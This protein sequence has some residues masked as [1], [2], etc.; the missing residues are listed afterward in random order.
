MKPEFIIDISGSGESPL[1]ALHS[2]AVIDPTLGRHTSQNFRPALGIYNTSISRICS[3]LNK[4]CSKL[5]EY[6]NTSSDRSVLLKKE[7][8]RSEIIDYL[9][10]SLYAAA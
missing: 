1:E 10:L 8:L 6:F 5:E 9:E 7:T 2:L 4:L 3:K